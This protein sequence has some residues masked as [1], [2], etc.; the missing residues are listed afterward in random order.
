MTEIENVHAPDEVKETI[1]PGNDFA[2]EMFGP[3]EQ[4][5]QP[6]RPEPAFTQ[7]QPEPEPEP[8]PKTKDK[9]D[10]LFPDDDDITDDVKIYVE[11]GIELTDAIKDIACEFISGEKDRTFNV[12][13]K[14]L[15]RLKRQTNK[16]AAVYLKNPN[17]LNTWYMLVAL[18]FVLPIVQAV[19]YRFFKKKE[20]K[21]KNAPIQESNLSEIENIVNE[22][23]PGRPSKE[24]IELREAYARFKR[25]RK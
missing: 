4:D 5:S 6:P 7:P 14:H 24:E 20:E 10:D 13:P 19:I 17:P 18:C 21:N 8:Q 12:N 23:K 15:A 9:T 2:D 22:K 25:N 3:T 1:M 16:I 11:G